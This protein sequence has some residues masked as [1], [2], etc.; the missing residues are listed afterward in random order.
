MLRHRK[1]VF[2]EDEL[3]LSLMPN[4]EM[5]PPIFDKATSAQA[6]K[7]ARQHRNATANAPR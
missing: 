2:Q 4:D 7:H 3:L 5:G 1:L 6:R